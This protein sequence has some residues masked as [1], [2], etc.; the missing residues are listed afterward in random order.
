[1]NKVHE[2]IIGQTSEAKLPTNDMYCLQH[3]KTIDRQEEQNSF[4]NTL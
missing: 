2:I 1:M 4:Y 3:P